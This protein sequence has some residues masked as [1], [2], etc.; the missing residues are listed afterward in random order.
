MS[1]TNVELMNPARILIVDDD[2]VLLKALD[3]KLRGQGYEVVSA[4]N[5]TEAMHAALEKRPDLVILDLT[6]FSE[7]GAFN[8]LTD[9]FSVLNWMRY[10]MEDASFPVV[11]YTADTSA[12]VERRAH[13]CK[14]DAVLH[15]TDP[16]EALVGAV[17]EALERKAMALEPSSTF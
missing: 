6:L 3:T 14:V 5:S 9:G 2:R 10:T 16:P 13:A 15:K 11:I 8:G 17:A 1:M 7:D 4:T 12:E